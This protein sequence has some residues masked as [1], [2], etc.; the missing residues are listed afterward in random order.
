MIVRKL[1]QWKKFCSS[2]SKFGPFFH[3]QIRSDFDLFSLWIKTIM[4]DFTLSECRLAE[5]IG[6]NSFDLC[7]ILA[8]IFLVALSFNKRR[9][10]LEKF[11]FLVFDRLNLQWKLHKNR[12][13]FLPFD[14]EQNKR[15]NEQIEN[16]WIESTEFWVLF[17]T[18]F[19]S[20]FGRP[21]VLWSHKA[22]NLCSDFAHCIK[23]H[24]SF[25][26]TFIYRVCSFALAK[27]KT[28]AFSANDFVGL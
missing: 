18:S 13:I 1:S 25:E 28:I 8:I 24:S 10:L 7:T 17:E 19:H 2:H 23:L 9:K 26:K 4:T 21:N 27:R 14:V 20:S 22:K 16:F 12:T 15:R 5:N 11:F 6:V 3:Q